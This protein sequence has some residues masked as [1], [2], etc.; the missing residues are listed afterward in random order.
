MKWTS[1]RLTRMNEWYGLSPDHRAI[2]AALAPRDP[3]QGAHM[4]APPWTSRP[5]TANIPKPTTLK[6]CI[7]MRLLLVSEAWQTRRVP[8][9]SSE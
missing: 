3:L 1:T 4:T 5:W 7:A 6:P 2:A 9:E 8:C